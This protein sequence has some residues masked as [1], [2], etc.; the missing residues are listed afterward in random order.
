MKYKIP[1]KWPINSIKMWTEI[2]YPFMFS[3]DWFLPFS[4]PPEY[5]VPPII[6]T[7]G[8]WPP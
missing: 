1:Q 3:I 4:C 8:L 7:R 6:R 2:D 5:A